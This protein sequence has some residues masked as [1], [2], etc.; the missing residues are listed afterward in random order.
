MRILIVEDHPDCSTAL[1]LVLRQMG[2]EVRAAATAGEA[3]CA[4]GEESF[5]LLISDIGLPDMT[6]WALLVRVRERCAV[7]AIA[8]TAYSSP[9]DEQRSRAA[10]FCVHLSKPVNIAA[11]KAAVA[12]FG[13]PAGAA[14]PP[15][16]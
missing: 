12:R 14:L 9:A 15:T 3:L 5:D 8:L 7:P 16:P 1:A 4:C 11:L 13:A 10:G 6:G 2:H